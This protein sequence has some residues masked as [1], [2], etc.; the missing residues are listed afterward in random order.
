ML[1]V[2]SDRNSLNVSNLMPT[3]SVSVRSLT[4][5]PVAE[6]ISK[7]W[8]CRITGERVLFRNK[9]A[10][11]TVCPAFLDRGEVRCKRLRQADY[12]NQAPTRGAE[13]IGVLS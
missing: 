6:R 12:G 1:T 5:L 8:V 9:R 2:R 4:K 3:L 13:C 10:A 7:M 11:A